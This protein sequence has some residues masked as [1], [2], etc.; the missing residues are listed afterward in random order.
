MDDLIGSLASWLLI[1]AVVLTIFG[2]G[3]YHII[4]CAVRNGIMEAYNSIRTGGNSNP[5]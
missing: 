2:G 4:K 1:T 3:L 5:R